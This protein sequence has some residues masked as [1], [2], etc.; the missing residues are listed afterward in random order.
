LQGV[1][2]RRVQDTVSRLSVEDLSATSVSRIS[3]ELDKGVED[4]LKR[5]IEHS[6]P[7]LFVDT[8]YFRVRTDSRH[9]TKAFLVVT[10]VL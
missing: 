9:I 4:F 3:K 7:Y 5:P 1:S 10:A 8:S 6:I 2:T